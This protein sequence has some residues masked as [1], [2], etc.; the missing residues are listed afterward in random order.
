MI[1]VRAATVGALGLAAVTVA[2]HP[3]GAIPAV[4]LC[5]LLHL[6]RYTRFAAALLVVLMIAT[7]VGVRVDAAPPARAGVER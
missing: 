2:L 6:G 5:A 4:V 3:R 1:P 7:L